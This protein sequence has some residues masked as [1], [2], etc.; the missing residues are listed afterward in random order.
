MCDGPLV[1]LFV[2]IY[3]FIADSLITTDVELFCIRSMRN[4]DLTFSRPEHGCVV[5]EAA[6]EHPKRSPQFDR[7]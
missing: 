1:M 4:S 7:K 5:V 3:T 6:G 2:V